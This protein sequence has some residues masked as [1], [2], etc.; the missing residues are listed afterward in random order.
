MASNRVDDNALSRGRITSTPGGN[1]NFEGF[2][3]DSVG[4]STFYGYMEQVTGDLVEVSVTPSVVVP[5]VGYGNSVYKV[6]TMLDSGS[7][8]NWVSKAILP[9]IKF[10]KITTI[11]LNVKHFNGSTTQ[12]FDLVLIHIAKQGDEKQQGV[13]GR[14]GRVIE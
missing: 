5:I 7:E 1:T 6:R 2:P 4:I 14:V 3:D 12:K 9:F 10:S 13:S 11:R 8:S